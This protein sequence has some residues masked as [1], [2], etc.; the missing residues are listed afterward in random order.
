MSEREVRIVLLEPM[1]VA[2]VKALGKTPERDAWEKIRAWA[3]PKGLLEDVEKHP[4]FGFNNP[5]PSPGQ[6]EYGYEFWIRVDSDAEPE[7]EIEIKDFEGGL[8]AVATCRLKEDMESELSKEIGFLGTWKKLGEWVQAS[9]YDM[10]RH[11]WLEK[12]QNPGAPEDEL[13]LDLYCPIQE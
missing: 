1:R 8:Y 4:V 11:Q 2:S 13:I 6:E 7:G 12:A 10:G 5:N 3:G 9:R